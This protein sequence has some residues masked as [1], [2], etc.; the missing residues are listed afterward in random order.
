MNL[1]PV[2]KENGFEQRFCVKRIL[3]VPR[4]TPLALS[5]SINGNQEESTMRIH[6]ARLGITICFTLWLTVTASAQAVVYVQ[7]YRGVDVFNA[8]STGAL[9]LVDGLPFSISGQMEG[10]NGKYLISVGT[11][12]LHT[13]SIASNG[14]VG[15]MVSQ[16]TS[17]TIPEA[18]VGRPQAIPLFLTTLADTSTLLSS[19]PTSKFIPRTARPFRAFKFFQMGSSG[20]WAPPLKRPSATDMLSR[21]P[22]TPYRATTNSSTV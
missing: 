18:S 20:F 17:Q 10:I 19:I 21:E 13:Y 9:T 15:R 8:T 22:S 16:V 7:T 2:W 5:Q 1:P 14:A 4:H 3:S 6:A 12:Y 11:T